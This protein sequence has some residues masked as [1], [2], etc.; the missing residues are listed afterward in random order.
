MKLC[1][2]CYSL[3]PRE[4]V[5]CGK[6]RRALGKRCPKGH[7]NLYISPGVTCTTCNEG[8][9][10][11]VPYLQLNLVVPIVTLLALVIA[12]RYGW[13]NRC[14]LF[15]TA[16]HSLLWTL[17]ILFDTTQ[18]RVMEVVMHLILWFVTLFLISYMLPQKMGQWVRRT[19]Q[20]LLRIA[21]ILV[22]STCRLTWRMIKVP[23]MQV[24][25]NIRQSKDAAKDQADA[26]HS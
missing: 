9:V 3:W 21:W 20:S 16:L 14:H 23:A 1:L 5:F 15:C 17:S 13:N 11:G 7:V 19:L 18:K 12:F 8:P 24:K 4:T 26:A 10:D 2:V 22:R 6:C 25:A